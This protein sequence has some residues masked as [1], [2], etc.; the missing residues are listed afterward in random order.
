MIRILYFTDPHIR[1][2]NPR[3]RID[4]FPAALKSKLREV[5]K[6]AAD[7]QC[8]AVV[9][10]GD[11]FDR[12]DPAYVVAGEFAAVLAECPVPLYTVPGNHEIYGYNLDTVP[13]TVL[14]LLAQIEVVQLLNKSEPVILEDENDDFTVYITGQGYHGDMDRS[15]ADYQTGLG[16]IMGAYKVHV[17][18]GM[19]IEKPLP[20]DVP[21]TL[22]KDL[23]SDADVILAGHE[24]VGFGYRASKC[25]LCVN[26]G[27]LGRVRSDMAEMY[28]PVQ[29]ALLTFMDDGVQVK[30]LPLS[31]A[32][33][34]QEVL[35]REYLVQQAEREERT[36]HFLSLLASE[37]ESRFLNIREIVDDIARRENLPEPVVQD[38]LNRLSRAREELGRGYQDAH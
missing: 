30:L 5:W 12:P 20:Y 6:L 9:C 34:G 29:V 2:N 11:L 18:H 8:Q 31:C 13:R 15:Q 36:E 16:K 1:G 19:L 37:G 33:P 23:K 21:H 17:V 24:H 22:I 14:G 25:T 27:A 7:Y 32:R 28:R 3:A 4:D 10:G 38:A 35:S 26:P